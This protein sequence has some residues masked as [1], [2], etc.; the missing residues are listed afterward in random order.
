[1]KQFDEELYK[2][3]TKESFECLWNACKRLSVLLREEDKGV[4]VEVRLFDMQHP[5]CFIE[6]ERK[7]GWVDPERYP[8]DTV[9][10][11]KRKAR[12]LE[13]YAPKRVYFVLFSGNYQSCLTIDMA[14]VIQ[15]P[16]EWKQC[17]RDGKT[18]ND[19]FYIVPVERFIPK[20]VNIERLIIR[21]LTKAFMQ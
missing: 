18:Y 20:L 15:Y 3:N 1:M 21:D 8:F 7:E 12:Y 16:S 19:E 5:L 14:Q 2:K 4:D 13:E 17:T 6:M 9:H 11:I 10:I